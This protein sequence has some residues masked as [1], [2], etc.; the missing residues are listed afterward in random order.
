MSARATRLLMNTGRLKSA[1]LV[2]PSRQHRRRGGRTLRTTHAWGAGLQGFEPVHSH[3]SMFPLARPTTRGPKPG[4]GCFLA[5]FLPLTEGRGSGGKQ[6]AVTGEGVKSTKRQRCTASAEEP[7]AI[8]VRLHAEQDRE[9]GRARGGAQEQ[10]LSVRV[11][12]RGLD[13]RESHGQTFLF[14]IRKEDS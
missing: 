6:S 13:R 4:K 1:R 9:R 7:S 10:D 12:C 2:S 8:F 11:G 14:P 5:A 3:N